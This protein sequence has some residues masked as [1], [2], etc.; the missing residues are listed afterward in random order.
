MPGWDGEKC[1]ECGSLY[2]NLDEHLQDLPHE[3][4]K[5]FIFGPA[6]ECPN[7]YPWS[8][9]PLSYSYDKYS[10]LI[11]VEQYRRWSRIQDAWEEMNEEMH[12]VSGLV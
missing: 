6:Y 1:P 12:Q 5:V 4:V 7:H 10:H 3:R 8:S 11:P 9:G 2:K